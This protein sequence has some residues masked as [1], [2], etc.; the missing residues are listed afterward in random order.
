MASYKTNKGFAVQTVS[1]DPVASALP[2][3]TWSSGSNL[4]EG[5]EATGS[6]GVSNSSAMVFG[7]QN[8]GSNPVN[9]EVYNGSAWS[10]VANLLTVRWNPAGFGTVTASIAT[11]GEN[12]G[13][14]LA[15]T[16]SWNGS[17][18]TE[19]GDLNQARAY[20]AGMGTATAGLAVAGYTTT[21][22]DTV[23]SWNGSS[24]TEIAEINTARNNH[25]RSGFTNTDGLIFGGASGA[26]APGYTAITESWNGS[27]WT[28]VANLNAARHQINTSSGESSSSALASGGINPNASR[29]AA[30]EF[31][32]GTSW[33]ELN[34]LSL[35]R[36]QMGTAGTANSSIA[37]S[38]NIGTATPTATEEWETSSSF[39][40]QNLGQVYY[41][42]GSNAFKVT[43]T[44]FG[45][46]SW[47]SGG[48]MNEARAQSTGAGTQDAG[49]VAG[50]TG[51]VNTEQYNGTAWTEVANL[52]V[53]VTSASISAHS[54]N[55]STLNFGGSPDT[56]KT[57]SWD[58]SSWTEVANLN[59]G[60]LGGA[61]FGVSN[62][63][64]GM[65]GGELTTNTELYDGSSWTEVN[66]LNS[67][68]RYVGGLGTVTAALV[69]AG[70]TDNNSF[71]GGRYTAFVESW[72]GTSWTEIANI[73]V[74]RA[75]V[76]TSGIQTDAIVFGG[77]PPTT[78]LATTEAWN[79]SSWTEV[80]DMAQGR[81]AWSSGAGSASAAIAAG[82]EGPSSVLAVTEEWNL[83][84]TI[85][86]KTITV[87]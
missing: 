33:T 82:G 27:A 64:A 31:F 9:A 16:N 73:N 49:I 65:A 24:W 83:S 10:E 61:G 79:G 52:N 69:V 35:A 17:A 48:D 21:R 84:E 81:R 28:E 6:A 12:P 2:T 13:G 87:G 15:T 68:R 80:A 26:G 8:P 78:Y 7:G 32:N 40:Q 30:T 62:T 86:N 41:N 3:G 25:G 19:V 63:S 70:D 77:A 59:S 75:Y 29:S 51:S 53:G 38:G 39:Q 46:G 54:P 11:G 47:A 34:D 18:W 42:S 5:R 23:E 45:A 37:A 74:G 66:N 22:V 71:P 55:A 4:N 1:T 20:C 85:T 60:R 14:N 67:A 76:G 50:G 56:D 57:E 36:A 72:N 43:Q 58:N 44:V